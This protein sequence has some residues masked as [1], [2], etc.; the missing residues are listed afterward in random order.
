MLRVVPDDLKKLAG[1]GEGPSTSEP[2]PSPDVSRHLAVS[3][4]RL[5]CHAQ[6]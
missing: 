4:N 6:P 1:C 2:P 3:P 5:W